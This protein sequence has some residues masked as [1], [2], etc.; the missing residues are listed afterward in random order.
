MIRM[1]L[2]ESLRYRI[3][4]RLRVVLFRTIRPAVIRAAL[5]WPYAKELIVDFCSDFLY[6]LENR[7]RDQIPEKRGRF[8]APVDLVFFQFSGTNFPPK[9]IQRYFRYPAL[10]QETGYQV[11]TF[12]FHHWSKRFR[13]EHNRLRFDTYLIQMTAE[14]KSP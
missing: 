4:Q 10:A 6:E 11:V 2:S 14:L 3:G 7:D 8:S 5:S 9:E 13:P 12:E 1:L